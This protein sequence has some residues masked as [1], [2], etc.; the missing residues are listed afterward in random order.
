MNRNNYVV[1]HSH[2]LLLLKSRLKRWSHHPPYCLSS[3]GVYFFIAWNTWNIQYKTIYTVD[4]KQFYSYAEWNENWQWQQQQQLT[5]SVQ[6]VLIWTH[7]I[8]RCRNGG[9]RGAQPPLP[10]H[11][12][13]L[14]GAEVPY[15]SMVTQRASALFSNVRPP[16]PKFVPPSLRGR[17]IHDS[18]ISIKIWLQIRILF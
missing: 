5:G 7:G 16:C 1:I 14:R 4:S 13:G 12:G 18:P 8:Q 15:A 9:A 2:S 3:V 10:L 17:P 11:Q 6:I